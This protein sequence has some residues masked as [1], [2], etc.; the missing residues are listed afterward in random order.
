MDLAPMQPLVGKGFISGSGGV[1]PLRGMGTENTAED[2]RGGEVV[3]P[4]DAEEG[5]RLAMGSVEGRAV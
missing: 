2:F 1:G 3:G 5:R 4:E